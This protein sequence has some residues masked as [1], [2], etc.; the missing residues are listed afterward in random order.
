[1][2]TAI[3]DFAITYLSRL[4]YK[5]PYYNYEFSS[6]TTIKAHERQQSILSGCRLQIG[7]HAHCYEAIHRV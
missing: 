1:M 2:P 5:F 4:S 3:Y 7:L 6:D